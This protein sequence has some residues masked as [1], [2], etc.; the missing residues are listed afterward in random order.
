M[1]GK[2]KIIAGIYKGKTLP[3]INTAHLRPTPNRVRETLFNW[4]MFEIK[5]YTCL[6]AFAGS[7]ALGIE[8]LS[9]GAKKVILL[10][11]DKEVF[12]K[13]EKTTQS[14]KN[15]AIIPLK[16]DFFTFITTTKEQFD[17]IFLDPPF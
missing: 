4:L 5:A 2:I 15:D 11:K 12:N 1:P 17:L 14:L 10:E 8:A 7:G 3:V 9:R 13:L 16:A 6:D